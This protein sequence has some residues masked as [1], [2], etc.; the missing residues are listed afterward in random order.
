MK[1]LDPLHYFLGIQISPTAEGLTLSQTKYTLDILER[2]KMH[3]CK[4]MGTLM[5]P[6]T[7]GLTSQI[8]F[9][10]P[11]HYRSIVGALQYLIL[12]HLDLSYSVNFVSQ[13]MHSPTEANYK[14]VKCILRYLKGTVDLGL[15]FSSHSTLD[16][17][18][19]SDADWA[20]CPTTR[21]STTGYCVFFGSNCISWSAK[22]QHTV[23]RSSSEAEY[24][25]MAHTTAELTWIS[26]LLRDLGI[27][28]TSMPLLL[29]D[30]ISALYMTV[31]PVFHA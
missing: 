29:C 5:M 3:D 28:L 23:S 17:Y 7:K 25:A 2:D 20:G 14:M 16:L 9:S 19:F 24:R 10:D 6:R 31:N 26:F 1:D 11:A 8:P 22:K 27:H 21:R 18:A 15:H 30:N 13:F 4:P 12:T